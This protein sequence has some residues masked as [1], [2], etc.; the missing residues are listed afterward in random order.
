MA[1]FTQPPCAADLHNSFSLIRRIDVTV[2]VSKQVW[3]L[4]GLQTTNE[5]VLLDFPGLGSA[6]SGVRDTFLSLQEL[7]DVQTILLL[8]NGRYPGGAIASKIRTMLEQDKGQDLKDRIIVGVGRFNQLP[9]SGSDLRTID[10]LLEEPSLSEETI[11]ERLPILKLTIAS[12]SNLTTQKKILF[13]YP[14]CTDLRNWQNFPVAC[15]FAL[16]NFY[17]N[18]KWPTSFQKH[19]GAKN[20]RS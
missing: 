9:L 14:N 6:D 12:A 17:R 18:W 2:E 19:N 7:Q 10:Q 4:S 5:F 1:S 16:Q 8:L 13:Y 20:G 3:D 11:L 15:K